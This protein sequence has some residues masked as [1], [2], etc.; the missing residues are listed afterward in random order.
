MIEVKLKFIWKDA[1]GLR[2]LLQYLLFRWSLCFLNLYNEDREGKVC[3]SVRMETKMRILS[4]KVLVFIVYLVVIS[5]ALRHEILTLLFFPRGSD[6]FQKSI[7]FKDVSDHIDLWCGRDSHRIV[8]DISHHQESF[9]SLS[10]LY[11]SGCIHIG[12]LSRRVQIKY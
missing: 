6:L 4:Q 10:S 7:H 11:V 5:M 9:V 3:S 2:C 1:G 12:R 8:Q